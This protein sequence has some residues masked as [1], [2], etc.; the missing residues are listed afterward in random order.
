MYSEFYLVK[1][2]IKNYIADK[3]AVVLRYEKPMSVKH[4]AGNGSLPRRTVMMFGRE[5]GIIVFDDDYHV[6]K[7]L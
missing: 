1:N 5:R 2:V 3:G 4:E 6:D 7:W